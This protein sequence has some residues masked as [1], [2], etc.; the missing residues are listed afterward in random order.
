MTRPADLKTAASVI[1]MGCIN[2][3]VA[4]GGRTKNSGIFQILK[5]LS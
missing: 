5:S 4:S 1:Y 2:N 3:E